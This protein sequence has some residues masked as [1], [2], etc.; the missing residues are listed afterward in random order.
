MSPPIAIHP[1][2]VT[3]VD[4]EG[5]VP[6]PASSSR[7]ARVAAAGAR[8]ALGFLFIVMGL[9]GLLHFIPDPKPEMIPAGALAFSVAMA[10]AGYF[11]PLLGA[12]QAAA[13]LLLLAGR[14]VPLALTMLA[15]VIVNIVAFHVFLAPQGLAMAAV[16]LGCEVYLAFVYRS[17]F[18]SVLAA[19]A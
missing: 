16:V 4:I 14:F 15:P 11:V 10:K 2:S 17:A 13:G 9:N 5:I 12:T 6:A 19:R 7:P 1:V 18:R 3:P 8:I